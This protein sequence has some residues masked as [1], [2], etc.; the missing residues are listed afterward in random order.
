MSKIFKE[1]R[2]MFKRLASILY[3]DITIG[4]NKSI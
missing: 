1:I 3:S 4:K 2:K